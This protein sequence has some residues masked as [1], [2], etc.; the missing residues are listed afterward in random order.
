MHW[1]SLERV[2]KEGGRKKQLKVRFNDW[3]HG[4]KYFT[5]MGESTDGKRFVGELNTGEKMSFSKRSRGWS[6]YQNGDE[7][8]ARAI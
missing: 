7:N 1:H 4:I 5:I 3:S 6:M 2:W 8:G